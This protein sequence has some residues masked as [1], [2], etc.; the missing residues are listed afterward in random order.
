MSG[1]LLVKDCNAPI[2]YLYR[3]GLAI[4]SPLVVNCIPVTICV[5]Q[6]EAFSILNFLSRSLMYFVCLRYI[7]PTSMCTS[8]PKK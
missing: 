6:D 8:I 1:R 3:V 5:G 4:N 2:T 7:L